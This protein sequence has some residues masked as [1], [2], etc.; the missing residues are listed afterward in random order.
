MPA[1]PKRNAAARTRRAPARTSALRWARPA[2][3]PA[4]DSRSRRGPDIGAGSRARANLAERRRR[5]DRLIDAVTDALAAREAARTVIASAQAALDEAVTALADLGRGGQE[6]AT[7]LGVSVTDLGDGPRG[8]TGAPSPA[9]SGRPRRADDDGV[10]DD[11]GAVRIWLAMIE[12]GP[13]PRTHGLGG[14]GGLL[15][16]GRV[17]A[18]ELTT[19]VGYAFDVD[20]QRC[21]RVLH[22]HLTDEEF[23]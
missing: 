1:A 13:A 15:C 16:H 19:W 22:E 7:I 23:G 3:A 21:E 12:R 5:Q 11:D 10:A 17:D 20:C 14:D 9:G 4:E 6:L 8:R 18:D 2:T